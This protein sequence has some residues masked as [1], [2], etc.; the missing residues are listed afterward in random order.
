[1]YNIDKTS[2]TLKR[3]AAG[4]LLSFVLSI[5]IFSQGFSGLNIELSPAEGNAHSLWNATLTFA[6]NTDLSQI[7]NVRFV[8]N[9]GT[10]EWGSATASRTVTFS[11]KGVDSQSRQFKFQVGGLLPD[12]DYT[13]HILIDTPECGADAPFTRNFKTTKTP[14]NLTQ[15]IMLVVDDEYRNDA[16]VQAAI[17]QYTE[18][19]LYSNAL[20]TEVELFYMDGSFAK[21]RELY[22]F[23]K[24]N[25]VTKNVKYIFFVGNKA[26]MPTR[27]QL[28][29]P[30]TNLPRSEE[31]TE[32]FVFYTNIL[33]NEFE[34]DT[35]KQSFVS[36]NYLAQGFRC[37]A[38]SPDRRSRIVAS[39]YADLSF[40]A[41]LPPVQAEKKMFILN[42]FQK[43]HKFKIGEVKFEKGI[44]MADTQYGDD[45]AK[46]ELPNVPRWKETTTFVKMNHT[47][48]PNYNGSDDVWKTDYMNKLATGSYEMATLNVHG[49]PSLHYFGITSK[50][51]Q[52]LT[53]LNT[54][55]FNF[56]SCSVGDYRSENYLAGTYLNKG[57]V[58]FI[59]SF[60]SN[61]FAPRL[62]QT[63]TKDQPF[64][65][66]ALG[67][68]FSDVIRNSY[69]Y[70][71]SQVLLG[72]PLVGVNTR[73][74][75]TSSEPERV[76]VKIYPNPTKDFVLIESEELGGISIQVVDLQ[77]KIILEKTANTTRE[78]IDL[79]DLSEGQYFVKG[80][81]DELF[82]VKKII[83]Q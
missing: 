5:K 55:C 28:L 22:D 39:R 12:T 64:Y 13:L 81:K 66:M 17:K 35:D 65:L 69:G 2:K 74:N 15:R 8:L 82:F 37:V 43:L 3:L 32:N 27:T 73:V 80:I 36:S 7:W 9:T 14:A 40:G 42:Y 30:A 60:S 18:D 79:K 16:D 53:A 38:G 63:F 23:L 68:P 75:I 44:L 59:N 67:V 20:P 54:L 24:N 34:Y 56:F 46:N 52:N 49:S 29:N 1:M 72:D 21:K 33:N 10:V 50:E 48:S 70:I 62:R 76:L 71:G 25:F 61:I 31:N 11:G 6:P 78:V 51:I 47:P 26:A 77:G 45:D 83:K 41:L 19:A 57:N 58:L 4:F